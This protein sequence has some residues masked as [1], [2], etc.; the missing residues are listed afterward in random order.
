MPGMDGIL[1]GRIIKSDKDLSDI[2]LVM[3]SSAGQMPE[4]WEQ[5]KSNFAACLSKPIKS[6]ALLTK[7]STLFTVG[8]ESE[9]KD[10]SEEEIES[11][12]IDRSKARILL[13][14]DNIVNQHV[15]QSMLQKLGITADVANNGLEAIE[16][17][18]TIPYDL[19]FMD[20]QMPEMDGLDACRHIRNKQ[21]SVLDHEVPIVAMTAH[22]MKGDREKCIEAGMSDYLSKPINLNA[23]SKIIDKWIEQ[24]PE[25]KDAGNVTEEEYE[26]PM[27]FD[28]HSFMENI[29]NDV[30]AARKIIGIFLENAPHHLN[31]L[32]EA[33]NKKEVESIIQNAHSLKGSSASVGGMALSDV[34]GK[35]ETLAGSGEMDA[36]LKMLPE[37]ENNY[38]LLVLELKK[39]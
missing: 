5:N 23:L 19:V 9:R 12:G 31:E 13:V 29:M 7:L 30:T 36:V 16:A 32:K 28:S 17:L 26:E 4:N 34:S 3:L 21:S 14:E 38:E 11:S 20:I 35:I 15:A 18:E 25:G 33:V 2:S 27:I 1:L 6:S 10:D 39:I 37:L 8:H 24:V 22:A